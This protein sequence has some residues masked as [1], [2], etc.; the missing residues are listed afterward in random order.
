MLSRAVRINTR[1][2]PVWC[3]QLAS[4]ERPTAAVIFIGRTVREAVACYQAHSRAMRGG[5][6]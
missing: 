4:I 6:V 2:G 1:S 5:V 3:L